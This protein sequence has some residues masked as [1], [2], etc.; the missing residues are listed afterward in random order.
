MLKIFL[1]A[2]TDFYWHYCTTLGQGL[3]SLWTKMK[4]NGQNFNFVRFQPNL[5]QSIPQWWRIEVCMKKFLCALLGPFKGQKRDKLYFFTFLTSSQEPVDEFELNL[6]QCMPMENRF[7]FVKEKG[8]ASIGG[9]G[10]GKS[11]KN[12]VNLK[13][14]SSHELLVQMTSY[15][16]WRVLMA[17]YTKFENESVRK[18]PH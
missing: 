7:K 13:K 8:V 4:S 1:L 15:L 16:I 3:P 5:V 9:L 17:R 14:S 12:W 6:A 2:L 18:R 11:G 10:E